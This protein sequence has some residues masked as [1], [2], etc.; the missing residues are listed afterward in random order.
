VSTSTP[1]DDPAGS[2]EAYI[3]HCRARLS[4]ERRAVEG[5][6]AEV[7]AA[8]AATEERFVA[9]LRQRDAL[10]RQRLG[11]RR[12][13]SAEALERYA[14]EYDMLLASPRVEEVT[15]TGQRLEILTAPVSIRHYG[16]IY[17]MGRYLIAVSLLSGTID[18]RNVDRDWEQPHPHVSTSGEPCLGN[19]AIGIAKLIAGHQYGTL[20]CVLIAFLESYTPENA[21]LD[22]EVLIDSEGDLSW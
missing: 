6:Q 15:L 22:V 5:S 10:H 20:A 11:L 19:L 13:R 7:C 17:P 2:R 3:N 1:D 18:I 21:Y 12:L 8:L 16:V 9:L 4:A 14:Q